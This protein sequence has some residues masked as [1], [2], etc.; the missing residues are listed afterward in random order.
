MIWVVDTCVLIDLISGDKDFAELSAKALQSKMDDVL[1]IAPITYVELVPSF[2]AS[3]LFD[4]CDF[5]VPINISKIM[6]RLY[7]D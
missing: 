7:P 3:F 5:E 4:D 6:R 2:N 1:T